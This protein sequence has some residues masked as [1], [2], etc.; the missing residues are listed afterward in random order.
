MKKRKIISFIVGV[1][2]VAML[3]CGCTAIDKN[4]DTALEFINDD[5]AAS[6]SG[7]SDQASE[8][9][10]LVLAKDI[11]QP[12]L[13][14]AEASESASVEETKVEEEQ[15]QEGDDKV[16]MVFI[17]DSQIEN[18]RDSSNDIASLVSERVPNSVA[19]NLGIG[20]TTAAL[21]H[22]TSD[23]SL[24]KWD[25]ISFNGITYG[26]AGKIDRDRVFQNYPEVLDNMN[27]INP[28]KVDYYFIEYGANDFF[29][30]M[31]LDKTQFEG[32]PLHSYYEALEEGVKTLQEI[33]PNARIILM[34][35][36]YGIYKDSQ[37]K[38]L[39]D[40]YVVSYGID[41]LANYARKALN[42]A[43]DLD[44]IDFDAMNDDKKCDLYLDTAEEYL[45]D[46]THLTLKGRQVFSRL[47]AHIPNYYEENEPFAYLENDIIKIGQFDPDEYFMISDDKLKD[48][49]PEAYEK[50]KAG[51]YPLAREHGAGAE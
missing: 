31:P 30:K 23:T 44:V 26:L 15:P 42:V 21:E 33:S 17:G 32:N 13:E 41:T 51:A 35:P 29:D 11:Y 38:F 49:Y 7:K 25:S 3:T 10:T 18:G 20:G 14:E 9:G 50:L 43:E 2:T 12:T 28:E 19:Y 27:S 22:S 46:G 45:L 37:G 40:S 39:G 5:L 24:S 6:M 34:T 8:A 36:F 4:A 48:D 1:T 47:L 16:V